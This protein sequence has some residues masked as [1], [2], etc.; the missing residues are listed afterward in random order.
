MTFVVFL[1][2]AGTWTAANNA[3]WANC[4][5]GT[6][7]S[8]INLTSVGATAADYSN[9]TWNMGYKIVQEGTLAWANDGKTS[10]HSSKTIYEI[11]HALKI[12]NVVRYHVDNSAGAAISGGP[13]GAVSYRL[14]EFQ[15][16]WGSK[17][18]QGSEHM[19]EGE[20]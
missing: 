20:R 19:L 15:L 4:A 12:A 9:F 16:H 17:E 10:T 5:T 14:G 18:G 11:I 2:P 8:P 3:D 13:L 7:Q 6:A 1:D